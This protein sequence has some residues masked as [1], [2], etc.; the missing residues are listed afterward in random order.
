M[1]CRNII[2]DCVLVLTAPIALMALLVLISTD[3]TDSML[4]DCM[5]QMT[6]SPAI[7]PYG[8]PAKNE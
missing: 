4:L 3:N 2:E 1:E 5:D 6:I 8:D 7:S